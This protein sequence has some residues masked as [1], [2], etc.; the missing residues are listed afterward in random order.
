[1]EASLSNDNN[2]DVRRRSLSMNNSGS[3]EGVFKKG[4]TVT[5]SMQKNIVLPQVYIKQNPEPFDPSVN[6]LGRPIAKPI[7]I[8]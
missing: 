4:A 5:S 2:F 3:Q 1:M 6:P 7:K 8:Y